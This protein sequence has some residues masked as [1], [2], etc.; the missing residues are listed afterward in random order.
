MKAHTL[1]LFPF[2]F[3]FQADHA[4]AGVPARQLETIS[5]CELT[6]HWQD[7]D[8]KTVRIEA[9][10]AIGNEFSEVY[11]TGCA[12]M[13]HIAWVKRRLVGEPNPATPELGAELQKVQKQYGGRAKI[14]VIGE[15]DGPAKVDVPADLSPEAADTMR[16][17]N[18]RYGHRNRWKFQFTFAKI[19]KVE[20]VPSGTPYPH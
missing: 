11:D 20:A 2:L 16:K 5:L 8:H 7:Y 19:E 15:F 6:E 3:I 13:D 18:S 14:T 1:W 17:V 12:T 10:Y 4:P 9:V